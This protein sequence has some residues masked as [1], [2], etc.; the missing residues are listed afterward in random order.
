M[1]K[2]QHLDTFGPHLGTALN[3]LQHQIDAQKN[4]SP[5]ALPPIDWNV[6]SEFLQIALAV[7]K[8][9]QTNTTATNTS[10]S[11]L[12]SK[13]DAMNPNSTPHKKGG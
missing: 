6:V 2:G 4:A 3:D 1:D 12:H 5:G 9:I 10:L 11:D 7:L 13:L 8:Q